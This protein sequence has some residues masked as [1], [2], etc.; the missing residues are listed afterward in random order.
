[1]LIVLS[2]RVYEAE[3]ELTARGAVCIS[4]ETPDR[5]ISFSSADF[6]HGRICRSFFHLNILFCGYSLVISG[7]FGASPRENALPTPWGRGAI[8]ISGVIMV[9][10][11]SRDRVE[12]NIYC[13]LSYIF[14][15]FF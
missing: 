5:D 4:G 3:S 1:M 14:F 2:V 12:G 9:I 6:W 10:R 7:V 8:R 13:R 11:G 15:G